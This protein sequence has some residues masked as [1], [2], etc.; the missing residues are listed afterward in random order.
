MMKTTGIIMAGGKSSR[1][2]TNKALLKIDGKTV[3][4]RIADE[5]QKCVDEIIV[6]TNHFDDYRFLGYPMVEDIYKEMGPMGGIH[7]GLLASTTEKNLVV[8]C[9]MPFISADLG[10]FLLTQLDN[11]QVVVPEIEDQ[12]HP[13]FAGYKKELAPIIEE[14]LKEN[15]LRI[16]YFFKQLKTKTIYLEDITKENITFNHENVYNMNYP[17]DYEQAKNFVIKNT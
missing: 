13:L 5:L 10:R 12:F 4:E 7:A 14:A 3:I 8:A 6:V 11:Y 15:Q 1:M 9:D 17:D 16:R 2:G